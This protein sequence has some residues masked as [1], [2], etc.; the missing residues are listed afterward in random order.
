MEQKKLG[1]ENV[2]K[3]VHLAVELGNVADKIGRT[4]G[5]GKYGHLLLL[6]D[7]VTALGS[8]DFKQVMPEIKDL[9]AVEKATL[10]QSVKEKFDIVDDKLEAVIEEG[11]AILVDASALV[12]RSIDLSKQLKAA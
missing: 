12:Q 2:T 10:L 7:E 3:C 6:M 5:A 9:D 4:K 8:V 1:I 11:L